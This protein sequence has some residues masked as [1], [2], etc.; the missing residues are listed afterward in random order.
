[1]KLVL[2]PN[3]QGLAAQLVKKFDILPT[4]FK[5]FPDGEVYFRFKESVQ[6]EKIGIL[7]SG[8]P[9]Q[10]DAVF[11][12]VL[13]S[14][15]LEELE[16]RNIIGILPYFPYARQDKRFHS[17]EPI[18]AKT[19]AR[20][21]FDSG[22]DRIITVDV[23]S[24]EV[25]EEFGGQFINLSSIEVWANYLK[26]E[27]NGGYFL[28]AP[29]KG[30]SKF[31]KKLAGKANCDFVTFSKERSLET[32]EIKE[33]QVVQEQKI[34]ELSEECE[35]AILS[36]DIIST[37]GTASQAIKKLNKVFDG[38]IIAAFTHGVFL[39]RSVPKL[40]RAGA[41]RILA[42]DSIDTPFSKISIGPLITSFLEKRE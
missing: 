42:T 18:S 33:L 29:D 24:E 41:D 30:R 17:G 20:S 2:D 21:L 35:T 39:P 3:Y 31:V 12:A 6:E 38:E 15:T 9:N 36:D 16:A 22:I 37:G 13:L 1:M 34:K 10:N 19:V 23:H 7:I 26:K 5:N 11:K 28:I 27:L 4:E 40:L 25:F 14:R 8:Y 32:G